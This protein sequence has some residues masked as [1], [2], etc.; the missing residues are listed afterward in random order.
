[1]ICPFP[2]LGVLPNFVAYSLPVDVLIFNNRQ[3]CRFEFVFTGLHAEIEYSLG[4]GTIVF[5]HSQLP[6][7]EDDELCEQL[8]RHV[9]DYARDHHLRIVATCPGIRQYI[10]A[11]ASEFIC[12]GK[13]F[14]SV[15]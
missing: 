1:M 7:D 12:V 8:I 3:Q 4:P 6:A 10:R 11:H 5:H 13:V 9:I 15:P 2:G 14:Q